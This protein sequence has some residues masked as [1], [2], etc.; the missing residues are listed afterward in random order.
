MDNNDVIRPNSV[1]FTNGVKFDTI[2]AMRG[3]IFT[4]FGL[5]KNPDSISKEDKILTKANRPVLIISD[6]KDN[7]NI[8]R[9]LPLSSHQGVANT[10][11]GGRLVEVPTL[12]RNN[13]VG[14]SYIDVKQVFT[15]NTY[16]LVRKICSVSQEIVDT[17]VALNTLSNISNREGAM[18]LCDYIK[19]RFPEL[20]YF[21]S[22]SI[23]SE[24]IIQDPSED[25][26]CVVEQ[27]KGV[28]S[29][30]KEKHEYPPSTTL[31]QCE[32]LYKDWLRLATDGFRYKYKLNKTQYQYLKNKCVKILKAKKNGF[33]KY[34][35]KG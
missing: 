14:T 12:M 29:S 19:K 6:N 16:Q 11:S 3:D 5:F 1:K 28:S 13:N 21:K 30:T 31:E 17:A 4:T 8:V 9:V 15:I 24:N 20:D 10:I 23:N 32:A 2:F 26:F 18:V 22:I 7:E 27:I 34:D 33:T 25:R 35:W